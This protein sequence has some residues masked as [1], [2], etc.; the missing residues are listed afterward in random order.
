[1]KE[2]IVKKN[3]LKSIYSNICLL[4]KT[5]LQG[6]KRNIL[7]QVCLSNQIFFLKFTFLDGQSVQYLSVSILL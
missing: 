7:E 5:N 4:K 2:M 1:M 3:I 6:E